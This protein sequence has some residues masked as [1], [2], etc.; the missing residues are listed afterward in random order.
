[1]PNIRM[2]PHRMADK[3]AISFG[4]WWLGEEGSWEPLGETV[5]DWDYASDL[6]VALSVVVSP[7]ELLGSTG[8]S[9]LD[10]LSIVLTADCMAS[11]RTIV[12]KHSLDAVGDGQENLL[13]LQL[14]A[15]ELAEK[16]KLSAHLV[17]ETPDSSVE[18]GAA[19]VK[20]ARLASSEPQTLILEGTASRFPIDSVR[21][22][23]LGYPDVPWILHTSFDDL[24]DNFMSTIRLWV[25]ADNELGRMLLD[26]KTT[27]TVG[28]AA[29][30]Y[31]LHSL[32]AVL[33]DPSFSE[34]LDSSD[35][36]EDS[37]GSIAGR[38][39]DLYLGVSLQM[40]AQQYR[41]DPIQFGVRVMEKLEPYRGMLP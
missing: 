15:G 33:A 18:S 31:V 7:A 9:G 36:V 25:N 39:C 22:G 6:T 20:G 10:A 35:F 19:R 11:S 24:G 26:S 34:C 21:F 38:M 37:V 32:V 28:Y 40:A 27:N 4:S 23:A 5:S 2:Y 17:V 13:A 14:P 12:S 30:E 8:Q 41:D 29:K 16:I 1:M 3:S